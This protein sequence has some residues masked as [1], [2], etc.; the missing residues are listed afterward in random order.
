MGLLGKGLRKEFAAIAQN[1]LPALLEKFKEKK[2]S[3]ISAI[4]ETLAQWRPWC[5]DLSDALGPAMEALASK[6]PAVRLNTLTYLTTLV[7]NSPKAALV[8]HHKSLVPT[9]VGVRFPAIQ[10]CL[11]PKSDGRGQRW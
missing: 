5:A 11:L 8:K 6:V 2:A 10:Y 3:V 9:V 4:H 7:A 1:S